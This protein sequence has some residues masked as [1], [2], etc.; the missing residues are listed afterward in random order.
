VTARVKLG[1]QAL[2]VGLVLALL[3]LLIWKV[4]FR[5]AGGGVAAKIDKGHITNAPD[6]VLD[7]IDRPG[8]LRL[9]S[10]RGKAVVLN[11]WA[12]WCYPCLKEAPALEEAWRQHQ[13]RVVVLGVDTN[14][15]V[16]DARKFMR[17]NGL[18]Y[19]V[20]HDNHD[21]VAPKYGFQF[22]PETFFI[23][24]R[25]K[26]VAHVGGQVDAANLRVGI[27]RALKA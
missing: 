2:A 22:L 23:N 1:A 10:L 14:D 24:A 8:R 15:F 11:F 7:R 18:T 20:V 17:E 4:A 13:G 27:E 6:F 9:E 21:D 5:N 26:V 3:G 16:G 12:S 19:P 25:G